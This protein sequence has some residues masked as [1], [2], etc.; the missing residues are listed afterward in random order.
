MTPRLLILK[1]TNVSTNSSLYFL[2]IAEA[3]LNSSFPSNRFTISDFKSQIRLEISINSGGIL[4][5]IK[6]DIL[7][8]KI[9][10]L[11]IPRDIQAIPIEI[12]IRKQKWLL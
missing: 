9:E 8:K 1:E 10:G 4:V 3:Q 6:E 5:Y 12:N 11:D 2:V 7:F